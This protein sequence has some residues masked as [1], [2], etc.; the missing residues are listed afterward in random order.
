MTTRFEPITVNTLVQTQ[1]PGGQFINTPQ[2]KYNG[3]ARVSDVKA[4]QIQI[5]DNTRGYIDEANFL[6]RNTP[7]AFDIALNQQNYA[8]GY[9]NKFYK[10]KD[11]K[12]T[13][14]RQFVMVYGQTQLQTENL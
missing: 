12:E 5:G 11:V 6:M 2:L 9:R 10:V 7:N 13:S 8:I 4:E 14:D 1:S 3:A